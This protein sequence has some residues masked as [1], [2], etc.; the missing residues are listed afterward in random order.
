MKNYGVVLHLEIPGDGYWVAVAYN[1][2]VA[3]GINK[4]RTGAPALVRHYSQE[5]K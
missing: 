3:G 1:D 4:I 5:E 2:S